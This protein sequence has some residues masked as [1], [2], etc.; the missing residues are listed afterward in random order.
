MIH[1]D[2][3]ALIFIAGFAADSRNGDISHS[4]HNIKVML[5]LMTKT[6]QD[7]QFKIFLSSTDKEHNFRYKVFPDYKI[8]RSK[9][10]KECNNG[11]IGDNINIKDILR[12]G[13]FSTT[14]VLRSV[15]GFKRRYYSCLHCGSYVASTKPAYFKR[16]R[17]YL[18]D[19]YGA[20]V[21][22]GEADDWLAVGDNEWIAT[23]DKDIYQVSDKLIYNMKSG[24]V[25]VCSDPGEIYLKETPVNKPGTNEPIVNKNGE[26]RTT[27]ALKG[28]GYKWFCM[29]MLLGDTV[30]GI[31]KPFSGDGP[32]FLYK[33]FAPLKTMR[34][35]WKM[36]EF[37]YTMTGNAGI[38]ERQAKLLWVAREKGQIWSYELNNRIILGEM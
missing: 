30:D 24:E 16:M 28:N 7:N 21:V 32:V 5:Q 35:C 22:P 18:K 4:L 9:I 31:P 10:C 37:Y 33:L 12:S 20:I 14:T 27:K 19:K 1:V 2:G 11:G 15:D 29:L 3:D 6:C 23:H 34:E 38:L 36:V 26:I 8:N 13:R 25:E 17:K